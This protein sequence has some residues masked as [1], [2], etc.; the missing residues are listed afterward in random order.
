MKRLRSRSKRDL[1]GLIWAP[2]ITGTE[3]ANELG[4]VSDSWIRVS[5]K[6]QQKAPLGTGPCNSS[7]Q[8][9]NPVE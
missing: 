8:P 7:R 9:G 4:S 1:S 2:D 5:D 6:M 3:T